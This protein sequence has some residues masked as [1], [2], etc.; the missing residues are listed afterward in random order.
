MS[1]FEDAVLGAKTVT[2][3]VS[4]KAGRFVD[5]S[6]LRLSAAELS[7]NIADRYEAL[8][9]AVYDAQKAG[10][11]VGGIIAASVNGIDALY[12]RLDDINMKIA[13]LRDKKYCVACGATVEENALFCSRCGA[14]IE[15]RKAEPAAETETETDDAEV[16]IIIEDDTPVDITVD[17][18]ADEAAAE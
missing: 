10:E 13:R 18:V 8:G 12:V 3:A 1:I 2:A 7:K 17:A 11:D 9:R 15:T 16:E 6:R 4:E 14:R 5:I